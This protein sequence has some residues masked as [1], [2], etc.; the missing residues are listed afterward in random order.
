MLVAVAGF[1]GLVAALERLRP[2]R[3][4]WRRARGDVRTDALHLLLTGPL[5]SGLYDAVGRGLAIGAGTWIAARRGG[6]RLWPE[7]WP[8][9]AEL[10]LALAVAELGHYAFHRL[11]HEHPVAWRL[12]AVHHSA[13][14]LYWLN[15]T[16]FHPL[17][18]LLLIVCQSTPLWLLGVPERTF[19]AYTL[20]A[21]VYGQLQHAN[22]EVPTPRW[23]DRIVATPGVH[24]WHHSTDPREG[25]ANYGAILSIWDTLLGTL[26]RP[27]DWSFAGPVGI[28]DLPGFPRGYLAQLR[29]P[30]TSWTSF[31]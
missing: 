21:I 22:V 17:D 13:E 12:H 6:P 15:A 19:F 4:E 31:G 24:R 5:T 16:R 20:F 1:Y 8:L 11:C 10:L 29:A 7:G 28:R 23:L 14:R 26:F 18:L 2:H 27:R 25:N 3:A 9:A 30:F